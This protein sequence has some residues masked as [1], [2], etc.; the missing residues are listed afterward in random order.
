MEGKFQVGFVDDLKPGDPWFDTVEEALEHAEKLHREQ[1][2]AHVGVWN[3]DC[4]FEYLWF[5]GELFRPA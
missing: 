5:G 2:E 1:Q 3:D 4:C